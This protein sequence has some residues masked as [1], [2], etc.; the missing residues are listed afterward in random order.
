MISQS[1]RRLTREEE[2]LYNLL[3]A[4][5]RQEEPVPAVC[6]QDGL[7]QGQPLRAI[8]AIIEEQM[9]AIESDI[10]GLYENWFIETCQEWVLPYIGDLLGMRPMRLNGSGV[11]S[12]RAHVA[13]TQGY[14]RR[15]GTLFVL[16]KA[17]RDASGWPVKA[18]EYLPLLATAQNL[19]HIRLSSPATIDLRD[20]GKLDLLGGPF[21]C[22]THIAEVGN[23]Y[24]IKNIGLFFWRINSYA[25]SESDACKSKEAY[26]NCYYF[27]PLGIDMPLYNRP[28]TGQDITHLAEDIDVPGRL[29]RR[30]LRDEIERLS[31]P[32]QKDGDLQSTYFAGDPPFRIFL[33]GQEVKPEEMVIC[34]L[35]DWMAA[36]W[37][38][39]DD[40]KE[41][42]EASSKDSD[43]GERPQ[44]KVAVDPELGR[45]VLL[46]DSLSIDSEL[47]P[48]V[49]VSYSY[50]FAWEIGAGSYN[51]ID[52]LSKWIELSGWQRLK[53]D[54]IIAKNRIFVYE[55]SRDKMSLN[56]ALSDWS[57]AA[58]KEK[59]SIGIIIISDS[60][61]LE[62]ATIESC[63]PVSNT[64]EWGGKREDDGRKVISIVMPEESKLAIV[65]AAWPE[66]ADG[67]RLIDGLEPDG[68]LPHLKADLEIT[69][70]ASSELILDGLLIEGSIMIKSRIGRF[71]LSDCTLAPNKGG[72]YVCKNAH[73]SSIEMQSSICGPIDIDKNCRFSSIQICDSIIDGGHTAAI[74]AQAA[75]V[76]I[77][78]STVLGRTAAL[79]LQADS[80]IFTGEVE[81]KRP[82]AGC[83]RFCY[84]PVESSLNS[85]PP[86]QSDLISM[87]RYRCQPDEAIKKAAT[88]E[89]KE[90]VKKSVAPSFRSTRFGHPGFC[91]LST[92]TP[93]EISKGSEDGSEMGVFSG[94]MQPQREADLRECLDEYLPFGLNAGI[95]Y[96]D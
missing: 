77:V 63:T 45:L 81:V 87:R 55:V 79:A 2:R 20:A 93:E 73:G 58:G 65:A 10:E 54:D 85:D 33:D 60:S 22:A 62:S 8:M 70:K 72:L 56:D 75:D 34:S 71:R 1:K 84:L 49:R 91:Q 21:E 66:S 7:A 11:F 64:L 28:R 37:K 57:K 40:C 89:E 68:L 17:A 51:R 14:R 44:R 67:E 47:E 94:I 16:E 6:R 30:P 43:K 36:G 88:P 18:R 9:R 13:N 4:V 83:I 82:Q 25:V 15:K 90:A 32:Q 96:V 92:G 95:F 78:A 19:N 53:Y 48:K 76:R 3:P 41:I 46:K 27:S 69:G 38:P 50:G 23:I 26:S 5:Y 31:C 80:S 12:Q 86:G 42:N 52:D 29:R 35:E 61:S 24:N 59:D 39:P 74:S